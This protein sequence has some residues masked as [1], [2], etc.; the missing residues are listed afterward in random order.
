MSIP[1]VVPDYERIL[2]PVSMDELH[3]ATDQNN[4]RQLISCER[5]IGLVYLACFNVDDQTWQRDVG[6]TAAMHDEESHSNR[7]ALAS[8]PRAQ[9]HT[10]R[11]Q[12][13]T[14]KSFAN[15]Q[16]ATVDAQL[17]EAPGAPVESPQGEGGPLPMA[18]DEPYREDL[19]AGGGRMLVENNALRAGGEHAEALL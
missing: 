5:K 8:A 6:L 3:L 11:P 18:R 13:Q 15:N 1:E 2:R 16:R 4:V 10:S 12:R 14:G 7:A 17:I 9:A 19:A